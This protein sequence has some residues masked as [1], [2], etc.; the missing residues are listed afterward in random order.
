MN[1][2]T[3]IIKKEIIK[4]IKP[5]ISGGEYIPNNNFF[6]RNI[7][8]DYNNIRF[9]F[10]KIHNSL[11]KTLSNL[12]C[13]SKK[14]IKIII[15]NK[16]DNNFKQI[17]K[18]LYIELNNLYEFCKIYD[19][20]IIKNIDYECKN[21]SKNEINNIYDFCRNYINY[22]DIDKNL[23]DY[24]K[25][26]LGFIH[27]RYITEYD[28]IIKIL[29][30]NPFYLDNNK[31]LTD[32]ELYISS[33]I[34]DMIISTTNI[35]KREKY[36]YLLKIILNDYDYSLFRNCFA[37]IYEDEDLY[38]DIKKGKKKFVK[39]FNED[40]YDSE[41]EIVTYPYYDFDNNK[42]KVEEFEKKYESQY[43]KI[44]KYIIDLDN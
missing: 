10:F 8:L 31:I 26:K 23:I 7:K 18:R 13:N 4:T 9:N 43:E 36:G 16:I 28:N 21:L 29:K 15:D 22:D 44:I 5:D 30:N 12:S 40:I 27:Y 38:N 6:I 19:F 34:S 20:N 33:L 37:Y 42:I 39:S 25:T 17:L 41:D 2:D 24:Y 35:I 3:N 32:N 14:Y 1:I 11:L